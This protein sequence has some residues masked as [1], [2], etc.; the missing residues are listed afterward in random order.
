MFKTMPSEKKVSNGLGTEA[1]TTRA[2]V[3]HTPYAWSLDFMRATACYFTN[4]SYEER[5]PFGT[6]AES[7][8]FKACTNLFLSELTF[9]PILEVSTC[10]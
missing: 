7:I 2:C 4:C 9:L 8:N 1:R 10:V 5:T 6:L 3:T